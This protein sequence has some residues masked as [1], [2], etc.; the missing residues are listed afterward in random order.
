MQFKDLITSSDTTL[1]DLT[2]FFDDLTHAG[3]MDALNQASKAHQRRMWELAAHAEP[4]TRQHFV[5]EGVDPRTEVIHH[6]RNTLPVFR[7]FQKRFALPDDGTDRLFGY[8]EG[9][10]RPIIGPGFFVAVPT[11][12]NPA[13]EARG[14]WVV[15]YF[16]VP[17]GAIPD[18]WPTVKPN[19]AGLQVLV[20]HRTRDFMRKVSEHVSIGMAFKVEKSLNNWFVLNRED[21]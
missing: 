6:G 15:D 7:S 21:G 10:T 11:A 5:P 18:G 14:A 9:A 16:Q 1:A 4:I 2:A 3:R 20:Y 13:W 19:S 8:N 17:D 12:G